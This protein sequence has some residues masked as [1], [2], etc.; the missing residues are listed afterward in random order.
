VVVPFDC[1]ITGV[2]LLADVSGDLVVDIWRD[3][4]ADFPPVDG[5]SIT[6]SAPP[7]I[8]S[9]TK[10][11]DTTLTGWT[12]ALSVGDILRFNVDSVA[13]IARATLA[14]ALTRT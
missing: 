2:T 10:S 9:A 12:T 11:Q 3:S 14:L 1:T 6:A 5:D 4:Y 7:T 8:T 13:T